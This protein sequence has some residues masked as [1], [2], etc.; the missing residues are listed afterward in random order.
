MENGSPLLNLVTQGLLILFLLGLALLT[1]R[2]L[3]TMSS[4]LL[5]PV[6]RLMA[7]VPVLRKLVTAQRGR[8]P[9]AGAGNVE[10]APPEEREPREI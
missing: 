1:L 10:R 3:L 7:A 6:A 5:P 2:T 8:A 4:L 9:D